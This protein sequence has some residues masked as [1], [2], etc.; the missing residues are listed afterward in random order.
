M[1]S[2]HE[3][4]GLQVQTRADGRKEEEGRE[5]GGGEAREGR[6]DTYQTFMLMV[7]KLLSGRMDSADF[8]ENCRVL[9]GTSSFQVR[10][11]GLV[12]RGLVIGGAC[13]HLHRAGRSW[14][15]WLLV[16]FVE[17]VV[18]GMSEA[19]LVHKPCSVFPVPCSLFPVPYSL[20]P[21]PFS[22]FRACVGCLIGAS[23]RRTRR[24]LR[25]NG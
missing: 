15:G 7:S 1:L 2:S 18:G 11:V 12:V 14:S 8:E 23:A 24:S 4:D 3:P 20:F 9:L 25:S 21:V 17:W 5:G 16:I 22:V 10:G 19:S 13:W 6:Q